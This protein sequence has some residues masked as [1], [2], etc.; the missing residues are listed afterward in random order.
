MNAAFSVS[1]APMLDWTTSEARCFHRFLAPHAVLYSEMI[2]SN[3]LLRGDAERHLR[4]EALESPLVLQLAGSDPQDLARAVRLAL[5]YGFAA[6]NFNA[7]CPSDRVQNNRVG[8]ILMRHPTLTAECLCAMQ[9]A[10]GAVLVSLKHRLSVDE[11]PE[12]S[13]FA[14]L[15][16]ILT[17]SPCRVFIV[18]ARRAWLK[19]LS[20]KENRDIPA[21]NYPIVYALKKSFPQAQ[22]ILNGGIKQAVDAQEHLRHVD[23]VM[24]GRA[25]FDTPEILLDLEALIS[26]EAPRDMAEVLSVWLHYLRERPLEQL[27][28]YVPAMLGLGKGRAG[29][30]RYRQMLSEELP[31]SRDPFSVLQSALRVLGFNEL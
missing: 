8:A 9:E 3:A 15:E 6:F 30:R 14:W 11:M 4:H 26:G 10:A 1:V 16:F 28:A 5:P 19:G 24:L 21:L 12:E 23:G 2:H 17:H 31:R 27:R 7:G 22:I 18:H 25:V 20:P 29:A 13:V